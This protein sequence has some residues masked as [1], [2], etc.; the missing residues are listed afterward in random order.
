MCAI[1]ARDWIASRTT[2]S[3]TLI[4]DATPCSSPA[5]IRYSNNTFQV[6]T[7]FTTSQ[8]LLD[9]TRCVRDVQ[10]R[11]RVLWTLNRTFE[12]QTDSTPRDLTACWLEIAP[13]ERKLTPHHAV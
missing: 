13:C 7:K 2:V 10:T 8:D 6:C 5:T 9:A 4:L 11:F 3:D 1:F 12:T